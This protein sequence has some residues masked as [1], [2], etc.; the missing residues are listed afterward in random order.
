MESN[1]ENTVSSLYN[2]KSTRR[3]RRKLVNA[4][5]N[6]TK[7]MP[8]LHEQASLEVQRGRKKQ[9]V[10]D[11]HEN[12]KSGAMGEYI[13]QGLTPMEAGI[14]AG[15]AP[16]ALLEL[17]KTSDT[18]RRFVEKKL[19]EFKQSHLKVM[20]DR[21]DPKTSQWLLERS[22]PNEFGPRVTKNVDS[23]GSSTVIA[24]I[25]RTVQRQQDNPIPTKYVDITNSQEKEQGYDEGEDTGAPEPSLDPGGA[26]II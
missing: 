8:V 7:P 2:E 1:Q 18:Y 26:N 22:F 14:L 9:E 12:P 6:H 4:L 23:E 10:Q 25:F 3:R 15:F 24:A 17:Q 20:A 19:I 11:F 13:K 16:E 21:T 5:E